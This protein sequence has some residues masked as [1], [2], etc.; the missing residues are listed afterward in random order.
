MSNKQSLEEDLAYVR[1]AA[2][3]SAD[4]N[5]PAI[6]L[7][8]AAIC[9]CGF[10]LVDI[11]GPASVWI[12]YFWLFT[13]PAGFAITIWL[14][15]GARRRAGVVDR[16]GGSRWAL[17]FLG[18]VAA[19]LLGYAAVAT[20]QLTWAGFSL[21]WILLAALTYYLAGLHLERRLLPISLLLV[22]GYLI[23]LFMPGYGFIAAGVLAAIALV[24]MAFIGPR[25]THAAE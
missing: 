11:V 10:S 17:H 8:W 9:L 7:L 18:F 16:R 12:G 25:N 3:Q 20:G 14:A 24:A 2:E 19:G 5:V 22:A 15:R 23:S 4:V 1:A 13:T 21:H 6:Y